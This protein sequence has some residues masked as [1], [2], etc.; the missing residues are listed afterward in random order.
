[1]FSVETVISGEKALEILEKR[2]FDAVISDYQMP[3]MDGI[4]LL[5]AVRSRYENM[6]YNLFTG[7]GREEVV[8]EAINNGVDFYI[9]KGGDPK[10]QFAELAHKIQQAVIRRRVQNE[11]V[12]TC[13]RLSESEEALRRSYG[14]LAEK[15]RQI[16]ESESRLRF[17]VGFYEMADKPEKELLSYAIEGAGT[18]TGSPLAY[19]AFLNDSQEEMTIYAW[20]GAALDQCAMR[21]KPTVYRVDET[22]LWGEAVRQRRPVITNDYQ[23][24][25][26]AK[27]GY[28]EGHPRIERHMS[29]PVIDGDRIVIVVGVAN[30][31]VDYTEKDV[32]ELTLL[33][34]GLWQVLKRRRAERELKTAHDQLA[35][36]EEELR[37]RFEEL[38]SSERHLRESENKFRAVIDQ[39]VQ[40]I[41]LLTV[42]GTLVEANRAA[43]SFASVQEE[44]VL[45]KPFWNTPWWTHSAALQQQLR[46]GVRKASGGETVR[47]EATH[48]SGNGQIVHVD[49]SIKPVIDPDGKVRHLLAEG[50]DITLHKQAEEALRESEEKYRT[51]VEQSNDGIFI[52]QDA[53]LVFHNRALA[54]MTG[55]SDEELDGRPFADLIAPEDREMVL[56]RHAER[57]EGKEPPAIYEFFL[58]PRG[59]EKRI[60]VRLSVARTTFRGSPATI[61]TIR[62]IT[63]ER[64]RERALRESEEKFRTILENMQ[65]AY[66]RTD[67]I[68]GVITMVNPS[69]VRMFGY[70]SDAELIGKPLSSLFHEPDQQRA[71]ARQLRAAGMLA[72]FSAL[73]RKKDGTPFWVSLNIQVRKGQ[74]GKVTGT[75]ATIRDVTE[76]KR[77]EHALSEANLKMTL[78]S[79]VTRH[80]IANQLTV[81][82]GLIDLAQAKGPEPAVAALLERINEVSTRIA[83]QIE[84]TKI[85]E[86]LGSGNPQWHRVADIAGGYAWSAIRCLES[87]RIF[88]IFS[89]RMIEQVFSIIFDNA[90]RHGGMVTDVVVSCD[91]VPGGLKITIQDNGCGIQPGE[92]ENI[93]KKGFGKNTGL[94]LFLAREI[95]SLAGMTIRET[96]VYGQGARFEILVPEGRY[97]KWVPE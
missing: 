73:A 19:L 57:T 61:G 64:E 83:R 51:V 82:R 78:I 53:C 6:P 5:K 17:L 13:R 50:R 14:E 33:M 95:L 54:Q 56:T 36:S 81:L 79:G 84:V 1:M 12:S 48:R 69:A 92:K 68:D 11:L 97:R 29:I 22:G 85:Y 28:P 30:K 9:Q 47:F 88:E 80:D 7:R 4:E 20:S 3:G 91:P 52:A 66:I 63:E 62:N 76:R 21:E 41:G 45:G 65:D 77:M 40:F 74:E 8:I 25:N 94:G 10:S 67:T 38:A 93:F 18:I 42:D 49:F 96:G 24:D 35:Q 58:L 23:K 26:P 31:A 44:E 59:G 55:Y 37:I 34:Q 16:R 87:C 27:K 46:E 89:D 90:R 71:V 86:D 75:D 60:L 15:E 70:Q 32:R 2:Q 39:A 72:D 43:M